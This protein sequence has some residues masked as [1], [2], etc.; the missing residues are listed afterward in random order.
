MA[1][2]VDRSLNPVIYRDEV[3]VG[4]DALSIVELFISAFVDEYMKEV[5]SRTVKVYGSCKEN[6]PATVIEIGTGNDM[7]YIAIGDRIK[8]R[9]GFGY[10]VKI[11]EDEDKYENIKDTVEI[12]CNKK[13]YGVELAVYGN[14]YTRTEDGT[15]R[16][17]LIMP[18]SKTKTDPPFVYFMY[19]TSNSVIENAIISGMEM[20]LVEDEGKITTLVAR[21][22]LYRT[23][24]TIACPVKERIGINMLIQEM[25][26]NRARVLFERKEKEDG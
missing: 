26:D 8:P 25:I 2:L 18:S 6:E 20:S 15:S 7:A 3:P 14:I 17:A 12:L 4:N 23:R 1:K 21:G 5:D 11:V 19:E 16:C 24:V 13:S 22:D 10:N 9:S